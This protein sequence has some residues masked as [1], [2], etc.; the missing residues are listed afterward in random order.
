MGHVF[1]VGFLSL[2]MI[3]ASEYGIIS[4]NLLS[5]SFNFSGAE[6]TLFLVK[7]VEQRCKR[8]LFHQNKT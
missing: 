3:L 2:D 4:T 5:N 7:L 1:I 8:V 6:I